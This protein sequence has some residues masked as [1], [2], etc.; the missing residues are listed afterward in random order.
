[1]FKSQIERILL[2]DPET[3][4]IFQGVYPID[5]LPNR[6][7]GGYI[8][9][10]DKHSQPGSHWVAVFDDGHRVEYFDSYGVAPTCKSFLGPNAVYSTVTLQPI[11][12][13]AC[14]FYCMYFLLNRARSVSMNDILLLLS[15][16]D[17]HFVVK[18]Y[19]YNRF[20]LVFK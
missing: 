1:M 14:G 9:N 10:L 13:N 11:L 16:V 18:N 2:L 17:S 7:P 8:I 6:K 20:P 12:S 15:R 4:V 3:R 19:F 5:L